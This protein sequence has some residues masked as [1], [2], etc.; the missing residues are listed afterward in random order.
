MIEALREKAREDATC[1]GGKAYSRRPLTLEQGLWS[2]EPENRVS[3]LGDNP[4]S[5]ATHRRAAPDSTPKEQTR[6]Q[7]RRLQA[8]EQEKNR[9]LKEI[10][11]KYG[12]SSKAGSSKASTSSSKAYGIDVPDVLRLG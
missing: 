8:E 1:G 3:M 4:H 10:Y 2:Q 12:S 9:R 7:K 6:E 11:E 5:A